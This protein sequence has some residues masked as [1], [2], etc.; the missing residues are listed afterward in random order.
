VY[1]QPSIISGIS[2]LAFQ[3]VYTRLSPVEPSEH[4]FFS[5]A[6]PPAPSRAFPGPESLSPRLPEPTFS[7]TSPF[8]GDI[9][10]VFLGVA[11]WAILVEV[12]ALLSGPA[13]WQI[14][15]LSNG[16]LPAKA[17]SSACLM[18]RPPVF[19]NRCCRLVGNE[20]P[21]LRGSSS[22]HQRFPGY[23]RSRSATAIPR[24]TETGGS[25]TATSSPLACLP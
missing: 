10:L 16:S 7:D 5:P 18:S 22:P 4:G 21:T 19:T 14:N 6:V 12:L 15:V 11:P 24:S 1:A 8:W 17:N 23:T 13:C 2:F 9:G 20:L 3:R 25:S